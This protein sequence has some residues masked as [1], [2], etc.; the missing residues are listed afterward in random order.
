MGRHPNK[1]FQK[2]FEKADRSGDLSGAW[3]AAGEPTSWGNIQRAYKAWQQA[4]AAAVALVAASGGASGGRGDGLRG[5]AGRGSG[6]GSRGRGAAGG[7]AQTPLERTGAP[8]AQVTRQTQHQAEVEWKNEAAWKADFKRA[9][10]GATTEYKEAKEQGLL[11]RP[12]HTP[13]E[14]AAR[15]TTR[16][17]PPFCRILA[18]R[19]GMGKPMTAASTSLKELLHAPRLVHELAP[20]AVVQPLGLVVGHAR[21]S[22]G[23]AHRV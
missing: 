16:R 1:A 17:R 11:K 4:A 20:L 22:R 8:L 18:E 5:S 23:P 13:A 6:R 12:G 7:T 14:I 2:I 21:A 3:E 10:K 19:C 9:H 15:W